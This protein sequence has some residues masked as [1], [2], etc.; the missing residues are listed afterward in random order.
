MAALLQHQ[1][2]TDY[3]NEDYLQ[4]S[5]VITP[6]EVTENEVGYLIRLLDLRPGCRLLD[7]GCGYGRIAHELARHGVTVTGIDLVPKMLD[8]ARHRAAQDGLT[9]DYREG[10]IAALK[11]RET[12]DVAIMWFMAFGYGAETSHAKILRNV[13]NALRRGGT[14]LF[15]QY[16]THRL[17]RE[18]YPSL[19][20]R[21]DTLFIHRP[22][23]DLEHGRWG[24][25]RIVV[26][27]GEIR[28]SHFSCRSY[29][30]PELR[31]MLEAAG[32]RDIRFLGDGMEPYSL[33]SRKLV[34][35]ARK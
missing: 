4:L 17:A 31:A 11:Y 18:L 6:Q 8:F 33:T 23:P 22:R 1:E 34:I 12:H 2:L 7:L 5:D 32:F 24:A 35:A 9:I 13:C 15:D 16:N 3:Y 26:N 28:R 30:P 19:V 10:D 25:E 21:G 29:S 14:L 27:E 20:D